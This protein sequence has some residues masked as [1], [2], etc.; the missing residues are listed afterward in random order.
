MTV[1]R[2][3]KQKAAKVDIY[4]HCAI[5]LL[6]HKHPIPNTI[7][8]GETLSDQ[9][10]WSKSEIN[11]VQQSFKRAQKEDIKWLINIS[12]SGKSGKNGVKYLKWL[13]S[14]LNLLP[15]FVRHNII[16]ALLLIGRQ[17]T[18]ILS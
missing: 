14:L 1:L 9:D 16:M 18:S 10:L 3:P 6:H 17:P 4:S 13:A 5:P 7:N 15:F 12:K 8:P 11:A 2:L